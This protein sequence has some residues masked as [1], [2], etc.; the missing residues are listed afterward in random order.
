V[1]GGEGEKRE[2]KAKEGK[3]EDR[4]KGGKRKRE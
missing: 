2:V 4:K 3:G 1:Q